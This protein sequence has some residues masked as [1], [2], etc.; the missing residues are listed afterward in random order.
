MFCNY[1]YI[2]GIPIKIQCESADCNER[3]RLFWHLYHLKD[4]KVQPF[5]E[6][7]L[8]ET[9]KEVEIVKKNN[10]KEKIRYE[11][12]SLDE[13]LENSLLLIGSFIYNQ[14]RS[15]YLFLHAACASSSEL[16]VMFIGEPGSGKS[17]LMVGLLKQGY[18]YFSDDMFLISI[19]NLR[20]I[21]DHR[22]I[23][24]SSKSIKILNLHNLKKWSFD[25]SVSKKYPKEYFIYDNKLQVENEIDSKKLKLCFILK[26]SKHAKV[27]PI[28]KIK[29]IW[30]LFHHTK[31]IINF[32][33]NI[34]SIYKEFAK[35]CM[36]FAVER[37]EDFEKVFG[38]IVKIVNNVK[39]KE[40]LP[41][42]L[43]SREVSIN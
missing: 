26:K 19:D 6:Y 37:E 10:L 16:A 27:Y 25:F 29:G 33:K 36:F 43:T 15:E 18:R 13:F 17:T 24:L 23:K 38:L 39:K 40:L 22:S 21:P 30:L 42:L 14:L 32:E 2:A 8:Y 4:V 12:N 34:F 3:L 1:F 11:V 35:N 7:R 41:I 28:S 9:R 5:I 20:C 31:N